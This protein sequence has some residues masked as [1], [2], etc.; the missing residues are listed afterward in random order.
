NGPHSRLSVTC[1]D[2][3]RVALTHYP[4]QASDPRDRLATEFRA[5]QFMRQHGLTEVPAAL[6]SDPVSGFALYDWIDGRPPAAN[7]AAVDA[8]IAFTAELRSLGRQDGASELPDASEA[9]FSPATIVAQVDRRLAVLRSA[10]ASHPAL[11]A[12]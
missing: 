4:R 8:A 12:F 10:A 3:T 5:L 2:G 11:A 7:A 9:C 6:A 1:D